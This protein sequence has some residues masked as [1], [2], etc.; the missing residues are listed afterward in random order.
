MAH[1]PRVSIIT[2]TW[3][4]ANYIGKGIQSAIDQTFED[5]ELIIS[6]DG[7]P[8]NTAEVIQEWQKKDSR[9][10]YV[11]VPHVGRI[12]IVSNAALR[13]AQGEYVAVLDDDDYWIDR[14]KLQKQVSFL[15]AHKDYIGCGSF[16]KIIDKDDQQIGEATKPTTDEGIRRV[17]LYANPMA[18][19][20]TMFRRKEGGPYDESLKQ[21]ADWEFWLRAGLKGK[22]CNFPEQ[23]LAYRMWHRGSSFAN[24][25][26]NAETGRMIVQR[27]KNKYPGYAK[28]II[29]ANI[30]VWYS[31]TPAFIRKGMNSFLSR[32]KKALFSK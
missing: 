6:D 1:R 26:E 31:Y 2:A 20:T 12:A 11:R 15:D 13:E 17:A 25:R 24:Q 30:Y 16:F 10:K 19:S 8:D 4:R 9:I 28:A 29:L 14:E 18:N 21:F 23:W 27:Y 7:S 32:L 5:W 3:N 22:L